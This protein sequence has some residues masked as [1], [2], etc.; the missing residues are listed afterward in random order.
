MRM[1]TIFGTLLL[2]FA[3]I[4]HASDEVPYLAR[5]YDPA[6]WPQAT[7]KLSQAGT[8]KDVFDSG[9]RPYR[10]PGLENNLLEVKHLNLTILLGSGKRLPTFPM[11][12][13]NITPFTDGELSII[14]AATPKLTLEQAREEMLKWL[15]FAENERTKDDLVHRS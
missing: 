4:L 3:S 8:L 2:A 6:K 10:H 7:L 12:W 11:E 1:K 14:E 13:M 9:L 5:E 15:P